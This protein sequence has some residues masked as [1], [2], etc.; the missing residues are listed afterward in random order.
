MEPS[1]TQTAAILKSVPELVYDMAQ[2]RGLVGV[3]RQF[4]FSRDKLFFLATTQAPELF[5]VNLPKSGAYHGE[6]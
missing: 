6:V 3:P 4:T 1:L 5:Y 2:A